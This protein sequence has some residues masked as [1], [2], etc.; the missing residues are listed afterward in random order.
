MGHLLVYAL[1]ATIVLAISYFVK[2][3]TGTNVFPFAMALTADAD[4]P[5]RLTNLYTRPI[6]AGKKIFAGSLV[7]LD[8]SGN[9][10]PGSAAA[11][12]IADGRAVSQVD[13][14]AGSAG[15]LTVDVQKGVFQFANS[16]A[17][18]LIDATCI[19]LA[20]YIV[21]DG[22][23]AKT[24]SSGTRSV[25]GIVVDVDSN[26]VWVAVGDWY[27]GTG[28]GTNLIALQIRV[29]ALN[30][31][32]TFRVA[33]PVIGTIVSIQSDIEAALA[34]GNATLTANIGASA[35]TGGVV[36][37]TQAASAAG[38]VNSAAPSAANVV[39]VGS[40]I[41]VVVGGTNTAA[42]ACQVTILIRF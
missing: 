20:C 27:P 14:T 3:V 5:T 7:V 12:L 22:T 28:L 2:K 13:N 39:V 19:G 15:A 32:A 1:F 26:G 36:T 35:I 38:Q 41:N 25:A 24:S 42:V 23:V 16:S 9:A 17:G 21:D 6:A 33:S 18:D 29:A 4:T 10:N 30:A 31:V 11:G 40:D 37:I 34:T 8:A